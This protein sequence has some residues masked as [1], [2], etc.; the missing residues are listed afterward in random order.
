MFV[1]LRA[2]AAVILAAAFAPAGSRAQAPVGLIA[3]VDDVVD[4]IVLPASEV[5]YVVEVVNFSSSSVDDVVV[6]AET[7]AE[8]FFGEASTTVGTIEAPAQG[9]PGTMTVRAGTLASGARVDIRFELGL[10][11]A[12]GDRLDFTAI[13]TSANGAVATLHEP[14][15]VIAAGSPVLRWSPLSLR[16]GVPNAS[17]PL[18]TL[19]VEH[20]AAPI[21]HQNDFPIAPVPPN[22]EYRVYRSAVP[23][24]TPG[25]AQLV[26]TVPA[27]QNSSGALVEPGFY[28][29]T[30]V[31][32]GVEGPPSNVVSSGMGEP[33][34]ERVTIADNTLKARGAGFDDGVV[35]RVD[36]LRFVRPASVRRAGTR[37][38]QTGKLENGVSVTKYLR[39]HPGVLVCFENANGSIACA[40]F[41]LIPS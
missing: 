14:T 10:E 34:I 27:T 9:Q 3:A 13:V 19:R 15:F 4:P 5:E 25:D 36:G 40:P 33:T 39:E 21:F 29:V 8:T 11:A 18:G 26:L 41:G 1:K 37:V 20:P 24:V 12:A 38:V 16:S 23:T 35:V 7:P 28:A 32:D 30:V 2:I 6:R 31:V 22:V 17:T